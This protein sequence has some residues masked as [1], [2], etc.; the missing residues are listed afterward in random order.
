MIYL[1]DSQ[2]HFPQFADATTIITIST[3]GRTEKWFILNRLLLNLDKTKK[4]SLET[5][6]SDQVR[7]P[8]IHGTVQ[9]QW[10]YHVILS[11]ADEFTRMFILPRQCLIACFENC[12]LSDN[13]EGFA[14]NKLRF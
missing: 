6:N 12:I 9:L 2:L 4:K 1:L 5:A 10:D 14:K 3:H 13:V 8:R 11:Q 7:F